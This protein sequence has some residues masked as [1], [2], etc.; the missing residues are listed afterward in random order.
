MASDAEWITADVSLT[1]AAL[2][3]RDKNIGCLPLARTIAWSA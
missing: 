1:D 3:M 2:R